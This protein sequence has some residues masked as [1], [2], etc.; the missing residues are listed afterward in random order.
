MKFS[1]RDRDLAG[2]IAE[3]QAAV[4]ASVRLPYD[5]HLEW[6][7]EIDQL[8]EASHRLASVVPITLLL[9]GTLVFASTRGF[10]DLLVV[11]AE[12][13]IACAGGLAA[14]LVSG[15]NLSISAAMGFSSLFGIA[16]Q[17]GLLFVTYS[18]RMREEGHSLEEGTLAA[19]RRLL[20]SA[21]MTSLVAMIG[22]LPAALSRGIGSKDA[23]AARGLWSSA[24]RSAWR[25]SRACTCRRCSSSCTAATSAGRRRPP[26]TRRRR[27]PRREP[28]ALPP[29]RACRILAATSSDTGANP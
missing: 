24:A 16:I 4:R 13:P 19:A 8:N 25:C 2:A 5:T 18:Q 14:L 22:L 9:V 15:Q 10:A 27:W 17:D 6:A 29:G 3:A 1:V 11:L 20:R 28:D 21:L 12:I 7:G 26:R 23:A